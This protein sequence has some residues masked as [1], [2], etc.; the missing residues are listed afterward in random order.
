MSPKKFETPA[1]LTKPTNPLIVDL[2]KEW[3]NFNELINTKEHSAKSLT[4]L[5]EI[6]IEM[7]VKGAINT[8]EAEY[9]HVSPS[10]EIVL[11]I[12]DIPLMDLFYSPQHKFII[13]RQRK[14]R[15]I[16]VMLSLENEP[17]DVLWKNP[18]TNPLENL[19]RLSQITSAY[20]SATIDKATK[21][22]MLL[23]EKEDKIMFLEQQL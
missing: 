1:P 7:I 16:D 11:K 4:N 17:L 18:S 5:R 8:Q 15:K 20:A 23:K 19:N 14:K 12:E 22:Q 13:R 2:E 9:I 6:A 21:V 3:D 10:S